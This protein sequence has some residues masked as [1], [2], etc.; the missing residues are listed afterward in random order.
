ML[1]LPEW[2]YSVFEKTDQ[3]PC[4]VA[5][6]KEKLLIEHFLFNKDLS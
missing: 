6:Q 5:Y 4:D 3:T 1:S 2:F